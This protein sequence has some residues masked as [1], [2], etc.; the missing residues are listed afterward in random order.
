MFLHRTNCNAICGKTGGPLPVA[1][2]IVGARKARCAAMERKRNAG[3][4][5]GA[6]APDRP[7]YSITEVLKIL[8]GVFLSLQVLMSVQNLQDSVC[9]FE[10]EAVP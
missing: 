6:L 7:K 4:S 3:S 8:R 1:V 2:A 5:D 10:K 9:F